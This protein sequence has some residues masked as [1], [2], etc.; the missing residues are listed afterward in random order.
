MLYKWNQNQTLITV[1]L[2]KKHVETSSRQKEMSSKA[3][4]INVFQQHL[5]VPDKFPCE[6]NISE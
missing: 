5:T 4:S 1:H 6:N 3:H 2:Q